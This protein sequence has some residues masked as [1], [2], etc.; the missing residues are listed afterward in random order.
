MNGLNIYLKEDKGSDK[1]PPLAGECWLISMFVHLKPIE[2]N[3]FL[4]PLGI[5]GSL[6]L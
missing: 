5:V 1:F 4:G 3:L 6:L 2:K